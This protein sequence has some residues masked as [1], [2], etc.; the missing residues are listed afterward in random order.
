[1]SLEKK[2]TTRYLIFLICISSLLL[3]SKDLFDPYQNKK[4]LSLDKNENESI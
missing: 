2:V 4:C 1:M 3:I